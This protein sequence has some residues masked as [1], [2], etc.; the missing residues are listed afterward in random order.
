MAHRPE[1][2]GHMHHKKNKN[3]KGCEETKTDVGTYVSHTI[4]LKINSMHGSP[5]YLA[6]SYFRVGN[7]TVKVSCVSI[8]GNKMEARYENSM[9]HEDTA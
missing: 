3:R 4:N 1:A 2:Q 5:F 7:N 9:K 6:T 8:H